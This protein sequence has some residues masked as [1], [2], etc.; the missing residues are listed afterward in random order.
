MIASSKYIL[1]LYMYIH[2]CA[3]IFAHNILMYSLPETH[4]EPSD[5][6]LAGPVGSAEID[7]GQFC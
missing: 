1:K 2:V 3:V 5:I 4:S 7:E 6:F